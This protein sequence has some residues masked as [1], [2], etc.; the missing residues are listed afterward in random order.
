ML[1]KVFGFVEHQEKATY[2][3]KL[4]ITGKNDNSVLNKI[5]AVNI[6]KINFNGFELYVRHYTLSME[7]QKII[8]KQI[9]RKTATELQNIEIFF[10]R[11]KLKRNIY[12]LLNQGFQKK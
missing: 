12:G 2:G 8:S 5:D 11:K 10:L 4:T 1:K 9:L 3:Y 6:G 7:Q